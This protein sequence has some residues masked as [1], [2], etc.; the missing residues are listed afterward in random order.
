LGQN[1]KK[2]EIK[3]HLNKSLSGEITE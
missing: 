3:I 1:L 2:D